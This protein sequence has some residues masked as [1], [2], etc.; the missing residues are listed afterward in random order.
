MAGTVRLRSA[1]SGISRDGA[2]INGGAYLD[3]TALYS[4]ASRDP[5]DAKGLEHAVYMNGKPVDV[6][7]YDVQALD[8]QSD[9]TYVS[10][11]DSYYRGASYGYIGGLY[12]P[13]PRYR[14]GR[15][16]RECDLIRYGSWRG[17][18]DR[19][20]GYY[21]YDNRYDRRR[22]DRNR[23]F[24]D[25]TRDLVDR[26]LNEVL[27]HQD[28]DS[29]QSRRDERDRVQQ[30]DL[31][32]RMRDQ[33]SR[34]AR[35]F[36]RPD[37]LG[38]RLM[39]DPVI[40]DTSTR[41]I[42][43]SSVSGGSARPA[44]GSGPHYGSR[45]SF[46]QSQINRRD[47]LERVRDAGARAG[48][49]RLGNATPRL[50][51]AT[52]RLGSS[53]PLISEPSRSTPLNAPASTPAIDRSRDRSRTERRRDSNTLSGTGRSAP[54]TPPRPP[55][56]S[57]SRQSESQSTRSSRSSSRET[58]RIP[59]SRSETRPATSRAA[60]ART[61][62]AATKPAPR[63]SKPPKNQSFSSDRSSKS[64]RSSNNRS[65]S[66]SR[67]SNR[68][69][70]SSRSSTRNVNRAFESR[71]KSTPRARRYYSGG[72]YTDRYETTRCIKEE[73]IT[74]HIPADRLQAARFDGL[75]IALL[76]Q[77]GN[78]IPLYIPP[79]YIEGFSKANPYMN[80]GYSGYSNYPQPAPYSGYP[81]NPNR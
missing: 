59:T 55:R 69:N 3:I 29:R 66:S 7:T 24:G 5:Y 70:A 23:D 8:C 16:G 30:R 26:G 73:R 47:A 15:Y 67:S 45:R 56:R 39:T 6:M 46:D 62:R 35:T 77:H 60:P 20:V 31:D 32:M 33:R 34:S 75:S 12:R 80:S 64:N 50:G 25:R 10:Y 38:D 57:D 61:T 74:L 43:S 40:V 11:D 78:D 65:S 9:V 49:P 27:D 52:P 13:F 22:G 71:N 17:L 63:P 1:S 37:Q 81:T 58:P 51:N 79:N 4:T 19:Y 72:T 54:V 42:S 44:T 53:R 68:S 36:T 76:D 2:N 18:R 28:T 41:P 48:V 21:G 14:G